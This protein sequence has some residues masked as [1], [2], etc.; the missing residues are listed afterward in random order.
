ML[1]THHGPV[2]P[3]PPHAG[4]R[5]LPR[6]HVPQVCP[7]RVPGDGHRLDALLGGARRVL[8]AGAPPRPCSQ[9]HQVTTA[10]EQKGTMAF[11]LS[12]GSGSGEQVED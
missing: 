1:L 11:S 9:P 8:P 10:R 12:K 3:H 2:H 4:G 6:L 7:P 5:G